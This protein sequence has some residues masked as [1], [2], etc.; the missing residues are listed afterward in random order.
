MNPSSV[1][2]QL[3]RQGEMEGGGGEKESGKGGLVQEWE[4][5]APAAEEP[6]E[7]LSVK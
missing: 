3:Q 7:K 2:L 5:V 6:P 1:L 4:G